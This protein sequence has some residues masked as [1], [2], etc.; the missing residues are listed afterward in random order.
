MRETF[1]KIKKMNQKSIKMEQIE[2]LL[3]KK[4]VRLHSAL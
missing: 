1:M 3:M 4:K 2:T